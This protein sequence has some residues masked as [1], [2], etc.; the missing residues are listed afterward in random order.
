MQL[1]SRSY[2]GF[3]DFS[4]AKKSLSV[5]NEA[6]ALEH[7]VNGEPLTAR[8]KFASVSLPIDINPAKEVHRPLSMS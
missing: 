5:S 8:N 1:R 7:L 3:D 2:F 6:V 4:S